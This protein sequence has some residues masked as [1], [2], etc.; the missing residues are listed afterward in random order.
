MARSPT[1]R[2]RSGPG[3]EMR[4]IPVDGTSAVG[5]FRRYPGC[6][7]VLACALCG[8]T[9]AYD[10]ERV[11]DRLRELKAGGHTTRLV[12]VAR[13]VGR[14]CPACCQVRWRAQFGWPPGMT[15]GEA[16]R[17]ANRYRN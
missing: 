17:L 4:P 10:P 16:R 2:D 6:R 8:W 15:P 12:D 9:K 14:E 5:D 3:A 1:P 11:I 7:L 13:R